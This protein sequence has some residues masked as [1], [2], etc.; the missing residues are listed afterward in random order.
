M[1]ETDSDRIGRAALPEPRPAEPVA[2]AERA[3]ARLRSSDQ[4][5]GEPGRPVNRNS[6][7]YV[8]MSA[9]TGV[10][11]VAAAAYFVVVAADVLVLIGLAFFIAVGLDPIVAGVARRI[12]RLVSVGLVVLGLLALVCGCVVAML[13]VLIEQGA[14][15]RDQVARYR[16]LLSDRGTL[17]GWINQQ[18]HI[19]QSIRNVVGVAAGS[20]PEIVA[21]FVV[22]L[23]LTVYFLSDLPRI[24][25][26][27]V[28]LVPASR[29]PRAILIG[30]EIFAKVGAYLLGNVIL[31]VI[32]GAA[33]FAW[34]VTMGIPYPLLLAL[35]V[36]VLDLIPI[37]GALLA[38]ALV[39]LVALTVSLPV[40]VATVGFLLVY[41]LIEDYVLM[42]KIIGKTVRIPVV[43]TL[44]A[45]L[46]GGFLLGVIGALVAVP[47]AAAILLVLREVCFPRLDQT[48][49]EAP[50]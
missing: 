6:P 24:R 2:E 36:S 41:Q 44:V 47:L 31:S 25:H 49:S 32:A 35:V 15:L 17:L 27:L 48:S 37:A 30:D 18:L 11:V 16:D 5:L 8:A 9:A 12:P 20:I 42:P 43:L 1:S 10:L 13:S 7:V 39:A 21:S 50:G 45:V 46:I 4:P 22:V 34:A 23:V 19:E 33:T 3:A 26:A 38:G 28:R 40:C 29:R 14:Q